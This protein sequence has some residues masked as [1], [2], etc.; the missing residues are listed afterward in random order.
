ME[1][2]VGPR[3]VWKDPGH[4]LRLSSALRLASIPTVMRWQDGTW[5]E[6]LSSEL[7]SAATETD[8]RGLLERFLAKSIASIDTR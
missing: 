7:E 3:E 6:R 2:E 4:S 8:V 5:T 1:V